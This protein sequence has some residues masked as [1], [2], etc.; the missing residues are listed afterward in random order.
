MVYT[1]IRCSECGRDFEITNGEKEFFDKMGFQLP[2]KCK[3]CRGQRTYTQTSGYSSERFSNSNPSSSFGKS[4]SGWCFITTAACECL[5]KADDCY[6]LTLLRQFR[7]GWLA[8]Q[9][10]GE[11]LIREYY[12]IAPPIVEQLNH[13]EQRDA[14]YL[15]IWNRYILPCVRL[16]EQHD[17]QAC[18]EHY[19]TML[20]NLKETI[21][22][23][24]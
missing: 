17:Y 6:E 8:V 19:E 7:D 4:N 20:Q 14:I 24:T 10:D 23:E 11:E 9:P 2:K 15:D 22:K 12:R 18:L 13:A 5:G 21:L 16:I 1:I 3:Q